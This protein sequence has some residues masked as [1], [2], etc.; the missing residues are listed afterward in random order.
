MTRKQIFQN[1]AIGVSFFS[2]LKAPALKRVVSFILLIGAFIVANSCSD[3]PPADFYEVDGLISGSATDLS[4]ITGWETVHFINS[5]GLERSSSDS[6][7]AV[8]ISFSV[9]IATPGNYA[10][11]L[12]AAHPV[13]DSSSTQIDISVTG[14]DGFLLSRSSADILRGYSLKWVQAETGNSDFISFETP[15]RYTF[16]ITPRSPD[17]IQ[18][19]KFQMSLNNADQ[20]FGLGLPSSTRTDLSAADLFR[21]L[22]VMLPPS[23]AFK[24]IL[25][26]N[27]KQY[28][29]LTE[30]FLKNEMNMT[31]SISALWS[32]SER[33]V[34]N[35]VGF[36]PVRGVSFE[37]DSICNDGGKSLFESGFRFIVTQKSLGIECLNRLHREYQIVAG[38]DQRSVF[39]HGI[40]NAYNAEV[41][42]YPAPITPSF[43][44]QWSSD[45][46]AEENNYNPGG[47][48]ERI[49]NLS[50]PAGSLYNMPFLSMPVDY[51]LVS[52][53]DSEWDSELFTRSIQL[54]PF[55]PVMNLK[56]PYELDRLSS[57]EM[58]QVKK[59]IDFRNSLFPYSYTHAHYTRQTN[60]SVISGFRQHSN[61][62]L[63]GDAFLVAPVMNPGS[64]GR[65]VYFPD[66][67]RWY[68]YYSGEAFE[69]GRSWFVET[70]LEQLPLFVKAGSVIPYQVSEDPDHL[71]IEIYTG[72]AGAFRLVEDDGD[73]RA[74][75]RAEAARTMF[76]YNEIQGNLKLTIGAVQADFEGMNDQR[77]YSL[78]FKYSEEPQRIEINGEELIHSQDN[79]EESSWQYDDSSGDV[80]VTL[81]KS[82]RHEKRDIVIYL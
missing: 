49:E 66:G 51:S 78:I 6:A 52:P 74:Y 55:L 22:P 17:G 70:Q 31:A 26:T 42:Q 40:K 62:F 34:Q 23:W 25:G 39:F 54:L 72:D 67:R 60:E 30:S 76:R 20:P 13:P 10:F 32:A 47:Y 45:P 58:E 77:S 1:T 81:K 15:G 75:R 18:V 69:A 5:I 8:P 35:Q 7:S 2:R 50:D 59:A 27:E 36:Y 61:Q 68:N 71:K 37:S 57:M 28:Q 38:N 46:G 24:P 73:T 41:K 16:T 82:S 19:H 43:K 3:A 4:G 48:A 64:D 14:P 12:L 56:L 79:R 44:F 9:S 29:T 11:W 63:Y 53:G 65:I 21:E 80:V 33:D